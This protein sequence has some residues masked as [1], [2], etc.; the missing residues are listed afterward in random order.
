MNFP[1]VSFDAEADV[2]YV[3]LTDG[4]V[5]ETVALGDLRMI[6][7][8]KEGTI[9]GIEFISASEGVDLSDIPFAPT[10]AAAIG[11]SGLPIR[12]FA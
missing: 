9:L 3:Y 8:S 6:D 4:T 7:K 5:D 11:D 1:R 2:L 10:V 12:T